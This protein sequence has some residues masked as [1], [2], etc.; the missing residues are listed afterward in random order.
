MYM[1]TNF[2][3]TIRM[4]EILVSFTPPLTPKKAIIE[5][6]EILERARQD[7]IDI[8]QLENAAVSYGLTVWPYKEAF[9]QFVESYKEHFF[10]K[11][12]LQK[13]SHAIKKAYE[14]FKAS[15]GHWS[16][17]YKGGLVGILTPET[18]AEMN[19]LLVD[20]VNEIKVLAA[21]AVASTE[22]ERYEAEIEKFKFLLE[23][24]MLV[25]SDLHELAEKEETPRLVREIKQFVK[26]FKHDMALLGSKVSVH[27]LKNAF[28]HFKGRK[29]DL[30]ILI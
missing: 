12:L 24:I 30:R 17:L 21:Q 26:S 6:R 14:I 28:E 19:H 13:A 16:Q 8:D 3:Y 10:E 5:V 27:T 1:R 29:K 2:P 4:V 18:R 25:L 22:K 23:E 11:L 7:Q 20:I 9:N 15:G